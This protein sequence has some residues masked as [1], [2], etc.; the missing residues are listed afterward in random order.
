[1]NPRTSIHYVFPLSNDF[2]E[3]AKPDSMNKKKTLQNVSI[4]T[5]ILIFANF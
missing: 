5:Q 2:D 4:K 1:M 3:Y